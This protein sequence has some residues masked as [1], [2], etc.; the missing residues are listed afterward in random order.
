MAAK[1]GP[2]SVAW[3][4]AGAK[5]GEA[6]STARAKTVEQR[7][8][9]LVMARDFAS[10]THTD[11]AFPRTRH[12]D[13]YH[14]VSWAS[15]VA[16]AGNMPYRNG[17]NQESS[18]ESVNAY[19]AVAL[20]GAALGDDEMSDLGHALLAME[21]VATK[22]YYQARADDGIHSAA[23]VSHHMVGMLWQ[24][25][26]QYQTW[27]GPA[28][29]LVHGI[30]VLPVT[31]VTEHTLDA[32]FVGGG[33]LKVFSESCDATPACVTDGWAAFVALERAII[34]PKLAWEQV[35]EFADGV[36]ASASPAGNGNSRLNSLWWVATRPDAGDA[37]STVA[38]PSAI[39]HAEAPAT[40]VNTSNTPIRLTA[41]LGVGGLLLIAA[42]L[43]FLRHRRGIRLTHA[44]TE[45]SV[46][47]TTAAVYHRFGEA[48]A[49]LRQSA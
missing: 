45:D 8:R 44:P 48:D 19:A 29:Y 40:D 3:T 41:A 7:E 9:L 13:W 18:S 34:N 36:F 2:D 6:S 30:Q 10:P 4:A 25:L 28:S 15:G 11:P 49:A 5:R 33:Q 12:K 23:M 37:I 47:D 26:A 17:R 42:A 35:L 22:T 16:L 43:N 14:F 27:F 1:L 46:L 31:P 20:L 38:L 24:N 32:P 39:E 21:V